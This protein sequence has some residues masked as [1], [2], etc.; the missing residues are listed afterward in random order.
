[1][2]I[3]VITPTPGNPFGVGFQIQVRTDIIGPFPSDTKWVFD[4]IPQGGEDSHWHMELGHPF[5]DLSAIFGA[6]SD[7]TF[8]SPVTGDFMHGA[9]ANLV[10]R[11]QEGETVRDQTTVPISWDIVNGAPWAIAQR[12]I[13]TGSGGGFSED[14]RIV[15][16]GMNGWLS[17]LAAGFS[18]VSLFD[19]LRD[20]FAVAQNDVL[21]QPDV[22]APS[23]IV[24]PAVVGLWR[25]IGIRW[26]VIE[27]PAGIGNIEGFPDHTYSNWGQLSYTRLSGD[28][29]VHPEDT[30][31]E[32]RLVGEWVWG[33]RE[34]ENVQ[35]YVLPGVCVRFWAVLIIEP[36]VGTEGARQLVAALSS[37]QWTQQA[38]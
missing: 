28:G 25:W 11:F 37:A 31:Y 30:Q 36:A 34:P 26:Q 19:W 5:N 33:T 10:I 17:W 29:S 1:M 9:A 3:T 7:F 2:S 8:A 16:M 24:R 32:D 21:L 35:V 4:V 27:R 13:T 12:G 23:I 6:T 38:D 15:L 18:S 14:D 20:K 22:C